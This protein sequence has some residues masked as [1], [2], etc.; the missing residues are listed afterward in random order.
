MPEFERVGKYQIVGE[1][2]EGA[3]GVVYKA[4]DAVLNRYV[5]VKMISA[6]LKADTELRER[7]LREARAA[8]SLSHPNIITIYDFGDEHD[9]IYMAMELLVG[10]DLKELVGSPTLRRLE[11]KLG[12]MEQ[13]C[14]GMAFAHAQGVVHR[15]IK[16][17]NI[18]IQPNGQIKV[19][20][21]GLARLGSS[22][23]TKTGLVMGTPNY[24]SPEQVM[25]ERVDARSDVFSLGAVFYEMLTGHKPFEADSVHGVM[26]RVVHKEHP[27]VKQYVANLPPVVM[28]IVDKALAKDKK[29]RFQNAGEM[30]EALGQVRR[31]LEKGRVQ[32]ATLVVEDIETH[33][34]DEDDAPA[35]AEATV[36]GTGPATDGS[37]ALDTMPRPV[38]AKERTK[39]PSKTKPGD[40]ADDMRATGS[41]PPQPAPASSGSM[42]PLALGAVVLLGGAAGAWWWMN[43]GTPTPGPGATTAVTTPGGE[44]QLDVMREALVSTQVQL[45]ERDFQ[46]KNYASALEQA[47]RVLKLSPGNASAQKIVTDAKAVQAKVE[48]DAKR[49]RAALSAGNTKEAADQLSRILALDPKHPAAT[50][51]STRLNKFFKGEADQARAAMTR[52]RTEADGASSGSTPSYAKAMGLSREGE[53]AM[54]RGEFAVATRIFLESRDGF[55]KARRDA[56]QAAVRPGPTAAPPT[57]QAAA[58]PPP[59]AP[60]TEAP[61]TPPPATPEPVVARSLVASRTTVLGQSAK[62]G[63]AGFD[64]GGLEVRQ[65]A[66]ELAGAV[67]FEVDPP[68]PSAGQPF[69]VRVNFKNLGKKDVKVKAVRAL[70]IVDGARKVLAPKVMP[71]EVKPR[72]SQLVGELSVSWPASPKSFILDVVVVGDKAE[73]KSQLVW[74]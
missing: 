1:I 32:D 45:A 27:P 36:V 51:L 59:T 39:R 10:T 70:T 33:D 72:D 7:F 8:A 3:M 11:D 35:G 34:V 28:Q 62:G 68:A 74:R 24:M 23:M 21:F 54:S 41:Q 16:P 48:E 46:D 26:F 20:D 65:E 4:H 19:L 29:E 37:T 12:V 58:T 69:T 6:S 17:G 53:T 2:G 40:V 63:P 61:P 25:G 57:T 14:D 50:E 49:A 67:S 47:E 71:A 38:S 56:S 55:E 18:H 42:V 73:Y 31:A 44:G 30:R 64:T 52:A 13:I 60:P 43:R 15:D 9:R 5:A 66:A 22:D